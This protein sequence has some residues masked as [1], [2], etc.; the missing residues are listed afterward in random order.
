[1]VPCISF[2]PNTKGRDRSYG[3]MYRAVEI[4][5]VCTVI[6]SK[7]FICLLQVKDEVIV[8]PFPRVQLQNYDYV[9]LSLSLLCILVY[10][11]YMMITGWKTMK[12]PELMMLSLLISLFGVLITFSVANLP[13]GIGCRVLAA[14]QQFLFLSSL[15]WSS[16]IGINITHSIFTI[17]SVSTTRKKYFFYCIYSLGVPLLLVLI[18]YGLSVAHQDN[19]D[20]KVYRETFC[21]LQQSEVIYGLFLVPIYLLVG[22]NLILCILCMVRVQRSM[23]IASNDKDRWKKNVITC[24]KL[25]ITFGISWLL[26]FIFTASP[27]TVEL[28]IMMQVFIEIQGVLVVFANVLSWK[29]LNKV[30]T[31]FKSDLST[32]Q[33]LSSSSSATKP[34]ELTHLSARH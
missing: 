6:T 7:H 12:T 2:H 34:T 1:M 22:S 18:T 10:S 27:D 20:F 23:S 15:F 29:C 19:P 21:F 16:A 25:S 8:V 9:L 5:S 11:T 4:G 28:E 3:N 14:M 13:S 24:I 17:R 26:L 33:P 32:T 31:L 30:Q